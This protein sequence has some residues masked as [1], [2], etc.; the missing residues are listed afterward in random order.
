MAGR[1]AVAAA[2]PERSLKGVPPYTKS[3]GIHESRCQSTGV[4]TDDVA[5]SAGA[6]VVIAVVC[7]LTSALS[8]RTEASCEFGE[9][10][11]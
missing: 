8:G 2:F 7:C 6:S 3:A 5:I 11:M 10:G 9:K 1:P 4:P